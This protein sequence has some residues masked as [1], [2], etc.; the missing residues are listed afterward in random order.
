MSISANFRERLETIEVFLGEADADF[1]IDR[2]LAELRTTVIPNLRRLP[3]IGRRHLEQPPQS[4]E[5]LAQPA[6][7]S[8]D[9]NG[10]PT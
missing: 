9:E 4:V 6:S 5:A 3:R 10:R 1:A 7:P 2:L 8:A